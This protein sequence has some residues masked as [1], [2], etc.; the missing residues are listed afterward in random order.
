MKLSNSNFVQKLNTEIAI[1]PATNYHTCAP[2]KPTF[3]VFVANVVMVTET[4]LY[5]ELDLRSTCRGFKSYLE[6]KLRRLTTLGKLFTSICV[7]H[8]AV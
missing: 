3:S 7:C 6:Q 1:Q 5:S 4:L 8:Q 2:I